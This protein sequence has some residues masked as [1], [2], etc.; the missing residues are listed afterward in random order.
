MISYESR[1]NR[2]RDRP[3][4]ATRLFRGQ[5]WEERANCFGTVAW[6][7]DIEKQVEKFW[8][9]ACQE[10]RA[11]ETNGDGNYISFPE[12]FRPGYI[13]HRPMEIFIQT[14]PIIK[15]IV[16]LE[17]GSIFTL[18]YSQENNELCGFVLRHAGLILPS[19]RVF[20]KEGIDKEDIIREDRTAEEI[21]KGLSDSVKDV[22]VKYY[23][24]Q[25]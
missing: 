25:K 14:S 6:L 20:E 3:E 18:Q 13:G 2:L 16:S 15:P 1:L 23:Q 7:L 10:K 22:E 4:L 24:V 8:R 19:G 5:Y 12:A 9:Q 11:I 17:A 21:V